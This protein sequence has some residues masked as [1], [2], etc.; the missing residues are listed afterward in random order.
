MSTSRALFKVSAA[1]AK[2]ATSISQED[3]IAV[4]GSFDSW[5]T[6]YPLTFNPKS[7]LYVSDFID[8]N[9]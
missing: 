4:Q 2:D 7:N 3:S 6:W 5:K 8:K 1:L 9:D